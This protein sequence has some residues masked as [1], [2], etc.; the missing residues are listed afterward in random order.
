MAERSH[1]KHCS[2]FSSVRVETANFVSTDEPLWHV[3]YI[4]CVL[5]HLLHL[6]LAS[7]GGTSLEPS[8]VQNVAPWNLAQLWYFSEMEKEKYVLHTWTPQVMGT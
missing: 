1:L 2:F 6:L 4:S 7:A 5:L 8:L 3:L